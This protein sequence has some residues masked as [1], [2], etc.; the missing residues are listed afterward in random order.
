M[1]I[2]FIGAGRLATNLAKA[3]TAAG[4][5]VSA[6]YS[7]TLA[8]ADALCSVVG[9]SPA[10]SIADLPLTADAFIIAVKDMAI[11]ELLPQLEQGRE[12]QAFFHTSGS[13]ALSVFGRHACAG[14]IYPMQTFS[15]ERQVDFRPIPI[16]I[17]GTTE[18][19]CATAETIARSVS[20][21]VE[22]RTS[23]ERRRLHLAAVFACNFANHCY[24]L[25]ARVLEE[26]GMSFEVMLPLIDETTAKIHNM[27]PR[28]A[29]TGPAIRYDR[30]VIDAHLHM[31]D[32][33]PLSREVYELMSRSIH[34]MS[35]QQ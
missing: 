20:Q 28:A 6:V 16:F 31:L 9:G 2:V 32:A 27:P 7:R 25:S 17:E 13:V 29:Q 10:D 1:E 3:L 24:A 22:R 26:A 12:S 23:E 21:N 19:A 30:Q 5:R 14:V 18:R 8:N 15:K 33:D 4:H 35:E 34:T 11:A